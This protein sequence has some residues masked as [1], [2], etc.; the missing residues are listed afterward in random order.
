MFQSHHF[1]ATAKLNSLTLIF[2]SNI[3]PFKKKPQLFKT[4]TV[5]LYLKPASF[6]AAHQNLVNEQY[7]EL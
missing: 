1:N 2:L 5:R 4:Q 3:L 6:F 7:Q